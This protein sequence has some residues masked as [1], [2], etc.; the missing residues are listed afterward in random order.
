MIKIIEINKP[1]MGVATSSGPLMPIPSVVKP[2]QP[3]YPDKSG[4]NIQSIFG[5]AIPEIPLMPK[6]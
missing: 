4:V 3:V 2:I 5:P 6:Y 1:N